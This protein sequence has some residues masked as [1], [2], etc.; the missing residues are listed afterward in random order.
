MLKTWTAEELNILRNHYPTCT[1]SEMMVLIPNKTAAAIKGKAGVLKI[2]KAKFRSRLSAEEIKTIIKLYP[3]QSSQSIAD[4]IGCSIYAINNR[5]FSLGLKKDPAYLHDL[6]QK[7]SRE[8]TKSGMSHRFHKGN[9][10]VNKG[11]KMRSDV[12]DRM[13]PTMF[14]KG[15][16]PHNT[17]HDMAESIRTN[18]EGKQHVLIRVSKG[19]WIEKQIFLYEAEHGKI[20]NGQILWC[21]DGNTLNCDLDNWELISREES[22][23]RCRDSDQYLAHQISGRNA[24]VKELILKEY[25][26]LIEL[27]RVTYKL[28]DQING[29]T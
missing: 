26:E 11:C 2:T 22:I 8:L 18:R 14:T 28:K 9:V 23:R 13:K 15:H 6:Q 4:L 3:T 16:L 29:C 7:M 24:E 20:P 25:P 21:K 19:V 27:K 5:A 1:Q 17:K 12:Y 10:P